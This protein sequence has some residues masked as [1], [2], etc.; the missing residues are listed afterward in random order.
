[1]SA[2]DKIIGAFYARDFFC[3]FVNCRQGLG[4]FGNEYGPLQEIPDWSYAGQCSLI[5]LDVGFRY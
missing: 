2:V 4:R 1:M 5:S 3:W